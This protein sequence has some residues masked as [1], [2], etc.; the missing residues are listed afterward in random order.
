MCC[1]LLYHIT[2]GE[3]DLGFR[4]PPAEQPWF[5]PNSF[6]L[7][8]EPEFMGSNPE[9]ILKPPEHLAA[10]LLTD[11][12]SVWKQCWTS[13]PSTFSSL[14]FPSQTVSVCIC[15]EVGM[16]T[17]EGSC[18]KQ[19]HLL[20]RL[21]NCREEGATDDTVLVYIFMDSLVLIMHCNCAPVTQTGFSFCWRLNND[22]KVKQTRLSRIKDTDVTKSVICSKPPDQSE[23]YRFSP[24][25][26]SWG[27]LNKYQPTFED[28]D[29]TII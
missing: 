15:S 9:A 21:A 17:Y 27:D 14:S 24:F 26:P 4:Y 1:C 5:H 19:H 20:F 28:L 8:C 2:H 16:D 7:W 12:P 10:V 23:H 11:Q 6:Q 25:S 3:H 13:N 22:E 29:W 18:I